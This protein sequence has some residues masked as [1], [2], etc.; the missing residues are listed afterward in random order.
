MHAAF[1]HLRGYK[2]FRKCSISE[3]SI[4][5]LVPIRESKQFGKWSLF[6][7]EGTRSGNNMGASGRIA[8]C[9]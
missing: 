5:L 8:L 2:A 4:D 6:C 9:M 1:G 7:S 3:M